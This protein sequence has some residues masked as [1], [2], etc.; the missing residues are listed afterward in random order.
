MPETKQ[1]GS[2]PSQKIPSWVKSNAGWWADGLISDDD[3]IKG[4]QYLV[5]HG[6]IRVE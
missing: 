1:S 3:F 4:I 5:E 6:I 2:Q